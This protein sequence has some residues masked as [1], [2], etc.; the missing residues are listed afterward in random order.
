MLEVGQDFAFMVNIPF[1]FVEYS[2]FETVEA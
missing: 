1:E 2:H